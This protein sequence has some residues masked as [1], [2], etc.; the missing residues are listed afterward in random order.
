MDEYYYAFAFLIYIMVAVLM[1]QIIVSLNIGP[2]G[3]H[4]IQVNSP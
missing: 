4:I 1:Y 3:T 2:K